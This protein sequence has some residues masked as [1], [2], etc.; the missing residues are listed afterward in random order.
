MAAALLLCAHSPMA[1]A[2]DAPP[3]DAPPQDALPQDAPKDVLDFFRTAAEAL[4]DKDAAAFLGHF[5]RKMADYDE[6]EREVRALLDRSETGSSIE[7]V[8]DEGNDR[9]RNL[10]LDWLLRIDEDSPRRQI[11]KCTIEK[12]GRRWRITSLEPVSFFRPR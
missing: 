1:L 6:L 3:Q 12:Q 10:Q 11:V 2:Q 9:K 5:D 7:I 8:S 4:A